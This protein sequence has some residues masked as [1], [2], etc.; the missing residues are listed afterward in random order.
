L[1]K[2]SRYGVLSSF[3]RFSPLPGNQ[4]QTDTILDEDSE[5]SRK[6]EY[7][8]SLTIKHSP[9]AVNRVKKYTQARLFYGYNTKPFSLKLY[10]GEELLSDNT[11][12]PSENMQLKKW[13]FSNTPSYLYLEFKGEDSPDIYAMALDGY[14]GVAVDNIALRGSGGL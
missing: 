11:L 13:N 3:S 12:I 10:T 7:S 9:Y 1:V 14:S 4:N 2:H 8:A 5:P 6:I